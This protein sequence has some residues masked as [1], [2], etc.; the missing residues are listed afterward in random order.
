MCVWS[1][2]A[3]IFDFDDS[4][5]MDFVYSNRDVDRFMS[6]K[7]SMGIAACK[8]MGKTFLLKA[9]RLEM[10]KDKSILILPKDS[11]VDV[12]GTIAI[13]SMQINF[14]SSYSNWVSLWISCIAIYLL[15]QDSFANIIDEQDME[16]FPS[17][18]RKLLKRKNTGIFNVLHR[19]LSFKSKECLNEV[20]HAST[21]LYDYVQRIQQQVVIFVDKLEEPFNRGYYA[22]PGSTAAAQG[23]YNASIWSYSQLSFAEAVY[24]LYSGRHHIKIFYSI[25]KEA[26]FHGEQISSEYP[27]LRSRIVRLKYS[28]QELYNMFCLYI[29]KERK[30][31]LCCPE[32]AE[33]NPIKALVGLDTIV[34]RSGY[35]EESVWSYIY[36]HT[37]QRP[38]DIMEMCEAIHRHIVKAKNVCTNEEKTR[39][40]RRWVNEIST[41][42][43]MSYLSFYNR[44]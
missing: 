39:L 1:V 24:T 23:R 18:V 33:T 14:L 35:T 37:F 19:V 26:L 20:V 43:C 36:R 12:S 17:C 7:D 6:A 27:K 15:S 41:M 4:A 13:E 8:G 10:M 31:E 29:S 16:D 34:H 3:D 32:L 11:I 28:P 5:I 22:I 21:L 9:K 30:N 40:L 2:E 44:L 42:E 25:R 38:R